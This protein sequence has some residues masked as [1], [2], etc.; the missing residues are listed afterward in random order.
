MRE[1]RSVNVVGRVHRLGAERCR[2]VPHQGYV[3][4]EFGPRA[5][6]RLDT[7]VRRRADHDDL[8]DAALLELQIEV[9]AGKPV[10]APMLFDHDIARLGREVRMPVAAPGALRK[11]GPSVGQ[12]LPRAGITPSIIITLAPAPVR[13]VENRNTYAA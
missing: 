2:S 7:G 6:G 3:V 4:A 8:L 9:G 12:D 11:D 5:S 13:D 10:L 1:G